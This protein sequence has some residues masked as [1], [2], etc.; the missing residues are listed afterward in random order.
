MPPLAPDT[1]CILSKYLLSEQN[2][3]SFLQ[4]S[5]TIHI[6]KLSLFKASLVSVTKCESSLLLFLNVCKNFLLTR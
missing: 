6:V 2:L 4:S 5:L 3:A 1:E